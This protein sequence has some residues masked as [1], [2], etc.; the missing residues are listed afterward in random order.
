MEHL[1]KGIGFPLR[2]NVQ[3]SLQISVDDRSVEDA[4]QIILRT[5]PGERVYHPKFGSRLGELVFMPLN[6]QTLLLI[7][8]HVRE[9]LEQRRPDFKSR[10]SQTPHADF[11]ARHRL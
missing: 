5:S 1:G 8:L 4:I 7:Q 2:T 6:T 11:L 9:A 10:R 3:G